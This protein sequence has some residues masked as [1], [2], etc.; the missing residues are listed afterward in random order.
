MTSSTDSITDHVRETLDDLFLEEDVKETLLQAVFSMSSRE[1]PHG[2]L[3]SGQLGGALLYGPPGTG[4]THLARAL[5]KESGLTMIQ[6][7]AADLYSK[8]SGGTEKLVA[9]VFRLAALLS[10][11]IIFFDEADALFGARKS[12]DSEFERGRV[13]QLL[14]ET[15]KLPS[16]AAPM[17][18]LLATNRPIDLDPAVLHRIPVKLHMDI[19]IPEERKLMFQRLLKD[20]DVDPALSFQDLND[21]TVLY[22]GSDVRAMCVQA[23]R[24]CE[25]EAT[26]MEVS[27]DEDDG[28]HAKRGQLALRHFKEA[29]KT[30]GAKV[31]EKMLEDIWKFKDSLAPHRET[32]GLELGLERASKTDGNPRS[33]VGNSSL[34]SYQSCS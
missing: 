20:E 14:T 15:G 25:A 19:P 22:T 10:P 33:D 13:S 4:K 30:V 26:D 27:D 12:C 5:A 8:N 24:L 1:R 32:L 7:S 18:L 9:A 16:V 29:L 2:A 28:P 11:T 23:A 34:S 3:A 21:M 17:F 6:V 31:S